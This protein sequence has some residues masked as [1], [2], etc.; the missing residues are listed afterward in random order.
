[1][2]TS[3]FQM[4]AKDRMSFAMRGKK[5]DRVSVICRLAM[6]HIHVSAENILALREVVEE[7]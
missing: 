4:T 6:E 1:M 3:H 2:K 7:V 5:P